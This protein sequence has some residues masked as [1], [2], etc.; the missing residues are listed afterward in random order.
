MGDASI[1]YL[2][3]HHCGKYLITK[4][5]SGRERWRSHWEVELTQ[6]IIFWNWKLYSI[7][8]Y[9]LLLLCHETVWCKRETGNV[10]SNL[11]PCAEGSGR[12]IRLETEDCMK[13]CISLQ[14]V[15]ILGR[16]LVQTVRI[17]L[18]YCLSV[19]CVCAN[20]FIRLLIKEKHQY[21]FWEFKKKWKVKVAQ[22]CPALWD[23]MDC[24]SPG[25]SVHGFSRQEYWSGLPC[26]PA[27]DFSNLGLPHCWRILYHLSHQGSPRI[28]EWV[29]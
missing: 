7:N 24:S 15:R 27:G 14:R 19:M 18:K 2:F 17:L 23:R 10:S 26:P 16:I 8:T 12:W 21:N 3:C 25:S 6:I 1:W 13:V 5:D 4:G 29:A 22:S 28:L 20:A 11:G 9:C